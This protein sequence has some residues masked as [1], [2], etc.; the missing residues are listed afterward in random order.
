MQRGR[1]RAR[2]RERERE[3]FIGSQMNDWR[4]VSTTSVVA[5]VRCAERKSRLGGSDNL[6][7]YTRLVEWGGGIICSRER[8]SERERELFKEFKE[9]SI[10]VVN[11]S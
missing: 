10:C 7:R 1:E 2:E 5:D 8:E 11:T 6:E 9:F 3:K 4:S